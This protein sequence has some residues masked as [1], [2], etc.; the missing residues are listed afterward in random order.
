MFINFAAMANYELTP[1][2]SSNQFCIN[3]YDTGAHLQCSIATRSNGSIIVTTAANGGGSIL[4]TFNN[5]FTSFQYI[6]YQIKLVI[7]NSTGSVSIRRNG[8][9]SNDFS[10]TGLNTRSGST[11]SYINLI[12]LNGFG[13]NNT[14][15]DDFYMFTGDDATAPA[16]FQGDVRAYQLMPNGNSTPLQFTPST[17][18]NWQCVNKLVPATTPFVSDSTVG[19]QDFYTVSPLPSIPLTIVCVVGKMYANI[20]D[21]T[22]YTVKVNVTSAATT[23]SSANLSLASTNRW[24]LKPMTVDPATSVAWLQAAVDAATLGP[25]IV[26]SP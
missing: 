13:S 1:G 24:C 10:A 2:S 6:H 17:G 15:V 21:T 16:D 26:S 3:C 18:A 23:V 9:T 14:Y 8:N 20:S 19:H 7:N 5:V 12:Q 4:A 22:A 25:E 11:N